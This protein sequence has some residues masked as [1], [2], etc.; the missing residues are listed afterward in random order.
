M[1]ITLTQIRAFLAVR[2]T[3]SVHG[4]AGHLMVSQ[5][6]V[7]AAIASL[8]H[9]D[10]AGVVGDGA[11]DDL[12]LTEHSGEQKLRIRGTIPA[13][14]AVELEEAIWDKMH[15]A[16]HLRTQRLGEFTIASDLRRSD[17]LALTQ[18]LAALPSGDR[19]GGDRPRRR[20][21]PRHRPVP[22]GRGSRPGPRSQLLT[23]PRGGP[24]AQLLTA[25]LLPGMSPS[26][27]A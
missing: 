24:S 9:P 10:L 13:R 8:P 26:R 25:L 2:S 15:F 27:A 6:S 18:L 22:A 1:A 19:P 7:S 4:A 12:T 23:E 5:P 3:G 20:E 11:D 17:A 16:S 14:R 21:R